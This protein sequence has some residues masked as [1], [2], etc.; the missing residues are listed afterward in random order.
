MAGDAK[1]RYT[2]QTSQ[3]G[4]PHMLTISV[5]DDSNSTALLLTDAAWADLVATIRAAEVPDSID[6]ASGASG[7]IGGGFVAL[8]RRI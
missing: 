2:K 8:E 5:G 6:G 1:V 7:A 4:Y 3:S